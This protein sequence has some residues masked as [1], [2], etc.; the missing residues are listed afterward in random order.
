MAHHV[1]DI[2]MPDGLVRQLFYGDNDLAVVDASTDVVTVNWTSN[3]T[4]PGFVDYAQN[5]PAYEM[6]DTVMCTAD[7]DVTL[8]IN[9]LGKLAHELPIGDLE[10]LDLVRI[11]VSATRSIAWER[12]PDGLVIVGLGDH[13]S[14]FT[15][16]VVQFDLQRL[17]QATA[18]NQIHIAEVIETVVKLSHRYAHGQEHGWDPSPASHNTERHGYGEGY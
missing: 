11:D 13:P 4:A 10:S 8:G 2:P 15:H 7:E 5:E 12:L 1:T 6:A 16:D 9:E 17:M 3:E 14:E 18:T